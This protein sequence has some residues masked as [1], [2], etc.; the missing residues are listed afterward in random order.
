MYLFNSFDSDKLVFV[1]KAGTLYELNWTFS[2]NKKTDIIWDDFQLA[3][4]T[5]TN[6]IM[7]RQCVL[8]IL[9]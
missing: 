6:E 9:N 5:F 1:T 8:V 3:K 2:S 7:N 4:I